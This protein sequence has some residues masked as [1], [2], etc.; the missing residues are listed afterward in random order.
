LS[1]DTGSRRKYCK[2][3]TAEQAKASIRKSRSWPA[4]VGDLP[5]WPTP[6]IESEIEWLENKL[7]ELWIELEERK[8]AGL[9]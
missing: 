6:K 3:C 5:K 8:H 4:F 2:L 9:T 1:K 7:V